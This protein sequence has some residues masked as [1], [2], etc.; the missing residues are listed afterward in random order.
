MIYDTELQN[1]LTILFLWVIKDS[2]DSSTWEW[3]NF[4]CWYCKLNESISFHYFRFMWT[5]FT[6]F[7][8]R[9]M[10]K[11]SLVPESILLGLSQNT[12]VDKISFFG[13]LLLYLTTIGDNIITVMIIVWSPALVGSHMYLFLAFWSLLDACVSSIVS[14]KKTIDLFYKTKNI[15]FECCM[16]QVLWF[17]SSV[18]WRRSSWQPLPMITMWLFASPWTSFLLWVESLWH[19]GEGSHVPFIMEL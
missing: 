2:E 5:Y 19:S 13:F 10:Q 3:T 6:I 9:I 1:T 11:K 14:P 4:W 16:A 7:L 8:L 15:S 12:K 18:Q 17:S